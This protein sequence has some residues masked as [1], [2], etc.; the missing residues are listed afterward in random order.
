VDER[1][2]IVTPIVIVVVYFVAFL[3]R[4]RLTDSWNYRYY[5]PALTFKI[6]GAITLGFIYT[7]YYNGGD[8]FNYHTHGSR[9]LW[10]AF[11]DSPGQAIQMCFANGQHQGS[12]YE[13]SRKI[14]FF[15]DAP[16]FFIIRLAFLADLFTASSYCGTAV[17]FAFFSFLG[18]WLLF[19]TFYRKYPELHPW[20]A[21]ACLFVPSVFFWGSGLLKDTVVMAFLGSLTYAVDRIFIRKSITPGVLLL[22][23]ISVYVIFSIK[24]FILQAFLPASLIWIYYDQ[25]VN[26]RSL[27][28]RVVVLPV[29]LIGMVGLSYYVIVKVGEGD[30]RYS[31]D[32]LA[33]TARITATDIRFQTGRF[34]GSGYTL[35]ELDGTFGSMLRLA[36]A[37]VNASLFR[38]YLW[39]VRNPLM[40]LSA[41]E[42]A[43]FLVFVIYL[44]FWK[45]L[46][47][48]K[49]IAN[50]NVLFCLVF[51]ITFAFAVGVSTFNFGT[52]VRYKIPLIPFFMVALTLIASAVNK[53]KKFASLEETE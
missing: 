32:K 21:V 5:F 46:A 18:M 20:I 27:A 47:V 38:P 10:N 23:I 15:S 40:L 30:Q 48:L 50:P 9:H 35:G 26:I 36:P 13:Y 52:L 34:A 22:L 37:A 1:D 4:P 28:L 31:V 8:T 3:L 7:F 53:D 29:V 43:G 41:L 2:L 11:W 44:I 14:I 45:R 51:S 42:S 16:S 19:L 49:A 12:F 6:I 39:E 17:I 33:E 25:L 24:K